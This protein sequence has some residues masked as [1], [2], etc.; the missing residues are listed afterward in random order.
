MDFFVHHI[1]SVILYTP[2]VGALLLLFVPRESE[3][4]HRVVGNLFGVLG[5]LVSLPLLRWF[6]RGWSGF[7]FEENTAW[8][9]SIG[10]R[11]HLGIDG[12]SLLLVMLTTFL[13]MIAILSSWSAIKQRQKEYYILLLLLQTGMI[14]VFVSLDFFLFYVFWEVML[15]PMYFLI[16]VW[17]SDRR[18]Y[19]AIKFFLYTLA[20]SVVMLL[21]ILALYFYAPAAAD[22]TRTFDVPTLLAAAQTFSDPL[23]VWLFWGF[24]FAF[25]IKVPMFPFHTWLPDA[26]TEAPTAGSVILAGVLL[27]MGTY[28][29]I[30]FSL[31]LLPADAAMRAKIIHIVIV[32]SLIG[33][34]YGA[35]VCLMQ[36]DMKRLIAY[37]SVSHLGF[38][39]LGIFALNPNGLAGSVLQ[40]INHGISTG[41]LFLIVGVLYERRHTRLISEFGGLATPM[42]NFAAIYLIISLS[43]L[44]MPLLNGFIGEFTILQGAFQVSKAWAAWG[45]LGVV[46]GAAY[47]LW[48]YQRVMF[49]PVTQFA[50]EELPD[51]NLREYAT[52]VPLVIL[53]F[54]IGIY[55]K[56]FFAYIEKPV[57]RIVEQVNPRFYQAERSQAPPAETHAVAA[58]TK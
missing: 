23:K 3:G 16:G 8:I 2:L 36:K 43:S 22:G 15:V 57:Q 49:G 31:L 19:A 18:L 25:A 37:S 35:I 53:A 48:L 45:S 34:I 26:H 28:G 42:P 54:W 40:Q 52:L 46:L 21:A 47:L 7:A 29:F 9:P 17:G 5:F 38:C 1:L 6:K 51:L 12:V 20:G 39:T 55:P 24:F 14:G 41:A 10:A 4:A 56:P 58:E 11:Y 50:N 13:G 32:L 27:K 30:R 44:G 33:I